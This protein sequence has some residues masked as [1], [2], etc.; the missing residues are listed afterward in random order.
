[1]QFVQMKARSEEVSPNDHA[2]WC[3]GLSQGQSCELDMLEDG[4]VSPKDSPVKE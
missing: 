2:R 4:E 1:M 3:G